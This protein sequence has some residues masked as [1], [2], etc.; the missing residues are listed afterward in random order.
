MQK[1][2]I[3]TTLVKELAIFNVFFNDLANQVYAPRTLQWKLVSMLSMQLYYHNEV[4]VHYGA[5]V[6]DLI[7]IGSGACNLLGF[8]QVVGGDSDDVLQIP[9]ARLPARSWYGDLELMLGTCSD[10]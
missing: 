8:K 4:I 7:V 1:R 10:F 5:A 9:I 2:L 6:T 3:R